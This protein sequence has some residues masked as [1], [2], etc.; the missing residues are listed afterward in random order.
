M[1]SKSTK[2]KPRKKM[3]LGIIAGVVG[4]GAVAATVYA[5]ADFGSGEPSEF[6]SI[7][8]KRDTLFVS[9]LETGTLNAKE[10]TDIVC[11]VEGSHNILEIHVQDGQKVEKDMLLATIDVSDFD[12]KIRK[13]KTVVTAAKSSLTRAETEEQT[14]ALTNTD[15]IA[16]AEL[17]LDLAKNALKRYLEGHYPQGS[18]NASTR[19]LR[20]PKK[21][22]R[23]PKTATSGA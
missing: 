20:S 13:Q 18:P 22:S 1:Q 10:T 19:R 12:D 7:P 17:E 9:V 15:L 8:V 16:K 21:S 14:Q 5:V 6:T 3:P 2:A 4:L 11:E 23:A